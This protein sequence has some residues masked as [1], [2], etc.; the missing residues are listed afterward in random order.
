MEKELLAAGD[1]GRGGLFVPNVTASPVF[2]TCEPDSLFSISEIVQIATCGR[3]FVVLLSSGLA[4]IS[5]DERGIEDL[6]PYLCKMALNGGTI[7]GIDV[8]NVF[9]VIGPE[10]NVF[11]SESVVSF[12]VSSSFVCIINKAGECKFA[13]MGANTSTKLI[14][15]AIA[16]G[17]TED[18]IFVATNTSLFRFTDGGKSKTQINMP[19]IVVDISCSE[20][21]AFFIDRLGN[22]YK[23]L[24]D[25]ASKIFGLPPVVSLSVGIQHVAAVSVD[26]G[27]YVWGFNPS[28]QLGIGSD[29]PLQ[30]PKCVLR[31]ISYVVCGAQ[32]T[33]VIRTN[34]FPKIPPLMDRSV[35]AEREKIAVKSE[36]KLIPTAERISFGD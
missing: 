19:E 11:E 28:G 2:V 9:Y 15:G 32:N 14:D 6:K 4:Y 35:L 12:A 30:D 33:W 20:L 31:N 17:C 29:R 7:F 3:E 1:N 23:C 26:G 16:V 22:V 36:L 25:S 10:P 5:V 21:N 24:E 13:N 8:N 34:E 18:A 27:L